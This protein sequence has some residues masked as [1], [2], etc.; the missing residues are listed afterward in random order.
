MAV[1]ALILAIL[2]PATPAGAVQ[3]GNQATVVSAD[4]ARWTPHVL[5]GYVSGFAETEGLV[6][7]VGNFSSVRTAVDET[8]I[9]RTNIFAF[10]N[11]TGEITPLNV[12]VNGEIMDVLA[13]GDG[14]NVW[15]AGSFSLVNGTRARSIAKIN[16]F[17][18]AL[19]ATF[20]APA[21]DGRI[22]QL[23]LRGD[24]LYVTGRFLTVGTTPTTYFSALNP[25]TGAV[26]ADV[27]MDINTPRTT[28]TDASIQRA[29]ITPDGRRLV[30]IGN[31]T[32]V[33]GQTRAMIFTADL[34]TSPPTL[35]NWSTDRFTADCSDQFDSQMRDVDI[36][37][38]GSYFVVGTTGGAHP[39]KLCDT[40]S[41]WEL[42]TEAPQ[43][44][45]TWVNYTG[46]DTITR[47][48][49]T[50]TAIYLGGHF[51]WLNNPSG[52]NSM[53]PGAVVRTGL[54][55]IDPRDGMPTTW[56][57]TRA[58]GY[59]VYSF[60]ATDSGLWIG[61]DTDRISN[62]QYH[63]RLAF[64]PIKGG[65]A[66]PADDAG[67]LPT[68][69]FSAG[70]AKDDR[71]AALPG[72]SLIRREFS[73]TEVTSSSTVPSAQDW[74][75]GRGLFMVDGVLY[76]ARSDG[77]LQAQTFD[78]AALGTPT[79]INLNGLI[80]FPTELGTMTG[81]FYDRATARI[82]YT[83]AGNNN[84]YYRYFETQSGIPGAT[85]FTASASIPGLAFSDA[86]SIFLDGTQL[87]VADSTGA[88]TRWDWNVMPGGPVGGSGIMV[89]G[90]ALDG[91]N[92]TAQD[93]F[94]FAGS[95]LV[96]PPAAAAN[97][98]PSAA[99]TTASTDLELKVD[100]SGS[101]DPDGPL[102]SYA[103]SFGDGST[104]AGPTASHI[105][106]AAGRYTVY[107]TVA[108]F[109]NATG[110]TSKTFT[111][112]APLAAALAFRAAAQT[113]ANSTVPAV[114]VPSSVQAGDGTLLFVTVGDAAP[115]VGPPSGFEVRQHHADPA[116]GQDSAGRRRRIGGA[117]A[118]QH[119][120]Q[121]RGA[122]A[123]LQR[124][125]R[126]RMAGRRGPGH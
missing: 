18:G 9:A 34:T 71:G 36:S 68:S 107:L 64:M 47:V 51:R 91:M 84:L 25:S 106:Q 21:F 59:G 105:Y 103:W 93:T 55:A 112:T 11:N 120:G 57:P 97:Q 108:D 124:R 1:L 67:R 19:D 16:V 82:Y 23:L 3:R 110:T 27:R 28:Q 73:G 38:D 30:A 113:N 74:T 98:P 123:S 109:H 45:P 20:T 8:P 122:V 76:S 12:A 69:V 26:F 22:N 72:T 94:V 101:S 2:I 80:D 43:S 70:A 50:Q 119:A 7:A 49:V 78:G 86:R 117:G 14:Q 79:V 32:V 118:D 17:T 54:A 83:L 104:A 37:L 99:F 10:K 53:G 115:T 29:D 90:P 87:Y 66:M 61:S 89:S 85:R 5:D 42:G 31:F 111:V 41:R 33:N 52:S 126:T 63:G 56:N 62:S 60:V 114:T 13:V 100:G 44:Q 39:G 24:R 40:A 88:L 96:A 35:T 65:F 77:T 121:I 102:K 75:G 6:V 15:I 92:W 116:L 81:L 95:G 125:E 4:A 58:R 48:A 46:G